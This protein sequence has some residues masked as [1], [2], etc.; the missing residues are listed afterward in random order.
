MHLNKF[1][2]EKP[3]GKNTSLLGKRN[4]ITPDEF[5]KICEKYAKLGATLIGGCCQITPSHISKLKKLKNPRMNLLS[6]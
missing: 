6:L 4:D 5:L 1:L 2:K 3:D